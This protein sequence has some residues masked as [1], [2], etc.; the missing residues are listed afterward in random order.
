MS[1]TPRLTLAALAAGSMIVGPLAVPASAA[2]VEVQIL[3]IN[4]FHGRLE[5]G[6][7]IPGAAK[8]AGAVEQATAL[9]P[10]STVFVAAGDSVGASTFTSASQEDAPTIE[11]L[12]LMGL[13]AGAV[14]NHE[15]D[16]GYD[17]LADPA[18]HGIDGQGLAGWPSLGANVSGSDLAPSTVVTT[19]S[20]VAVGI[21]GVVTEQTP[22]LVSPDGIQGLGFTDPVAAANAAAADLKDR[23]LADVV[24][25]VAHEGTESTDCAS[26]PGDDPFGAIVT[27]ASAD[28]DAIISGHTHVEYACQ[29]GG[30]PVV[31]SGQY[32]AGLDRLV[33]SVDTVTNDVTAVSTVEVVDVSTAPEDPQVADLVA[34]AAAAADVVGRVPLG[35]I[36]EDITR[37][38][39]AD[40]TEDR[41]AESTLGNLVADV[42]LAATQG[43]EVPPVIAFMNPGGLRADL[44]FAQSDGEG[45]GVVT[46]REAADVQPFA[47]TLNTM[48]LTG[49]QIKLVLEQQW[50]DASTPF[51][52]LGV[53]A[54]FRYTYDPAAAAGSRILSMTLDGQPIDPAAGYRVTV[55]S[56]LAAGG[57]AFSAFLEGANRLDTGQNDLE[58]MV[59]YFAENGLV[60]PDPV[61][62]AIR[63]GQYQDDDVTS[64][65]LRAPG[66]IGPGEVADAT[67]TVETSAP[68]EAEMLSFTFSDDVLVVGAQ[69][70]CV[71]VDYV[72]ECSVAGLPAGATTI[73]LQIAGQSL[74]TTQ[75]TVIEATMFSPV[76]DGN[77]LQDPLVTNTAITVLDGELN[78]QQSDLDE[79]GVVDLLAR[80]ASGRLLL[81]RGDGGAGFSR[82]VVVGSGFTGQVLLPGDLGGDGIDDVLHL[83]NGSLVRF[84]G[85]GDG[86]LSRRGTL[87][88]TGFSGAWSLVAPGDWTGD[89]VPDLLGRNA[90]GQLALFPGTSTGGVR[91]GGFIGSG[92]NSLTTVITPGDFDG[93]GA[94]DLLGRSAANALYLYR[95]SGTGGFVGKS[96]LI[97]TG[98]GFSQIVGLGDVTSDLEPDLLGISRSGELYLY[99]G[100]GAG[101]FAGRGVQIG[102]A[103]SSLQLVG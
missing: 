71:V 39:T 28:V 43:A 76:F 47:N 57:D 44:L 4:D 42:Q 66:Q 82:P 53:S 97:G 15:F 45:D 48:T 92:W 30:R 65:S 69:E 34:E 98:W 16:R 49:S 17:W 26:I 19:A 46:Y 1:R 12:N 87:I 23:D 5:P 35:E 50:R 84:D 81:Y 41:G 13:D 14:G 88:A 11:A 70:G 55:N 61:E 95:G 58:A 73:A 62:R 80:D 3:G 8:L 78:G 86:T 24:V 90:A 37:A 40:G 103:W 29:I 31:Q 9:Y 51:L 36:T 83:L 72:A 89:A 64:F 60:S 99:S 6:R 38:T 52:H 63:Q 7:G 59:D 91:D 93:D 25:L 20:G 27:G 100:D 77:P 102:R 85:R 22:T 79:D 32:G 68:I 96:R 10:D 75:E 67:L 94:V 2:V 54:G 74:G 56:F 101:G 33:M 21:V 18:K